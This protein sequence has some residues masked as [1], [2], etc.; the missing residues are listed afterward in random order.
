MER[1]ADG[2]VVHCDDG[3]RHVARRLAVAIGVYGR[4]RRPDYRV[5]G[6]LRRRVHHDVSSDPLEG[7]RVLVVGGGNSAADYVLDLVARE[8]HVTLSYRRRSFVRMTEGHRRRL[9]AL[10]ASGWLQG[11]ARERRRRARGRRRAAAGAVP[12]RRRRDLRPRRPGPRRH[13]AGGV[14]QGARHR[15]RG[16]GPCSTSGSR[17]ASG[18]CT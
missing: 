8:K 18:A 6:V 13:D 17:A 7:S 9:E 5:P 11:P 16:P 2:F 10:E 1:V 3:D 4:L 14:P 15:V 12:R